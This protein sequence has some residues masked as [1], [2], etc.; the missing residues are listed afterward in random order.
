M[1]VTVDAGFY[2]SFPRLSERRPAVMRLQCNASYPRLL[3]APSLLISRASYDVPN[4][5]SRLSG[6]GLTE[7]LWRPRRLDVQ[8]CPGRDRAETTASAISLTPRYA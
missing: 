1:L 7:R 5:K 3:L 6:C 2:H 4:E 8:L